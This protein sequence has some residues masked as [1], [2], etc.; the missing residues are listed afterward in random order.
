MFS[1]AAVAVLGLQAPLPV[2]RVAQSRFGGVRM[3]SDQPW[4]EDIISTTSIDKSKFECAAPALAPGSSWQGIAGWVRE[5][6]P[7][8]SPSGSLRISAP[9]SVAIASISASTCQALSLPC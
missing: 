4:N 9:P 5:P 1:A 6:A 2:S 8:Q 7:P 3:A